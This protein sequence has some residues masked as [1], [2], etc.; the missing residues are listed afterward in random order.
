MAHFFGTIE[1]KG[2]SKAARQGSKA[3]GLEVAAVSWGG[4]VHVEFW[5]KDGVDYCRI[6][7][8]HHPSGELGLGGVRVLYEGPAEGL[9]RHPAQRLSA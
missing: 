4:M 3:S 2:G 8:R 9:W 6:E 5:H 1:G 7:G